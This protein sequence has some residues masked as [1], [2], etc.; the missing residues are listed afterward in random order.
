[1]CAC[2]RYCQGEKIQPKLRTKNWGHYRKNKEQTAEEQRKY[3]DAHSTIPQYSGW[4]HF[5]DSMQARA[6][7]RSLA[8]MDGTA[9]TGTRVLHPAT[10][11]PHDC[12][13]TWQEPSH[14]LPRTSAAPDC[15]KYD[16][17][18]TMKPLSHF[19]VLSPCGATQD[20]QQ[21]TGSCSDNVNITFFKEK[22]RGFS[23][24]CSKCSKIYAN[25]NITEK[26][27]MKSFR[28]GCTTYLRHTLFRV[29]FSNQ[30]WITNKVQNPRA[31][32]KLPV[33][34]VSRTKASF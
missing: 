26:H 29:Y 4:R 22:L 10:A 20:R 16:H 2:A 27:W 32:H 18:L 24:K 1:M 14:T 5:K 23:F 8:G 31:L 11:C 13:W 28:C 6:A 34:I 12:A 25:A 30:V 7:G 9:A 19:K 21:L 3:K 17:R 15:L 33:K